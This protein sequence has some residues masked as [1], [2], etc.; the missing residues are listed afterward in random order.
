MAARVRDRTVPSGPWE[1]GRVLR[2][3]PDTRRQIHRERGRIASQ[4]GSFH[5]MS[6]R[7]ARRRTSPMRRLAWLVVVGLVVGAFLV[8]TAAPVAAGHGTHPSATP[9]EEPTGTPSDEPTGTPSDRP[10]GTP[11]TPPS[12]TPTTP[13]SGPPGSPPSQTPSPPPS[14]PPSGSPSTPPSTPP[15]GSPSTPPSGGPSGSPSGG[16]SSTPSDHS[17]S[18]PTSTVETETGTPGHTL[19]PTDGLTGALGGPLGTGVSVVL[20]ILAA[21]LTALLFVTPSDGIRRRPPGRPPRR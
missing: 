5:R 8:P 12:G 10:T 6:S 16:P 20:M 21:V 3:S 1:D 14:T 18:T 2:V 4:P 19:P 9:T 13:P 15:S 7:P 17:T 11:T